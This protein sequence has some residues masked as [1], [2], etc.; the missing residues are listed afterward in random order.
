[1][2]TVVLVMLDP[3]TSALFVVVMTRLGACLIVLV[4]EFEFPRLLK[5]VILGN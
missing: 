2:G 3:V 5:T 1:M 4:V